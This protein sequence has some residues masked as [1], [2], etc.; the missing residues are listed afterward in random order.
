MTTVTLQNFVVKH[1]VQQLFFYGPRTTESI[2]FHPL[3]LF[4]GGGRRLRDEKNVCSVFRKLDSE[5]LQEWLARYSLS[6]LLEKNVL[7]GQP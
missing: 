3:L 6:E 5:H 7:G 2:F 4:G 1:G